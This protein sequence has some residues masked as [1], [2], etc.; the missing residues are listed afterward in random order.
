MSQGGAAPGG[1]RIQSVKNKAR[2][3]AIPP[4]LD[5]EKLIRGTPNFVALPRV[6]AT[7]LL[8]DETLAN[9]QTYIQQHVIEGGEP[10]VIENWHRRADWPRW[11]FNPDWLVQNHGKDRA[12]NAGTLMAAHGC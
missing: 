9:L 10:L 11:M 12:S 5:V 4:D 7:Q 3:E 1:R 8:D 6:D 2:F